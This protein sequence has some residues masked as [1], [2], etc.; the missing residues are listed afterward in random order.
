M[1]LENKNRKILLLKN[2]PAYHKIEITH[3][4]PMCNLVA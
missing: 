3:F 2:L 4:A 1:K